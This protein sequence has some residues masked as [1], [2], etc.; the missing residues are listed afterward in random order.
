MNARPPADPRSTRIRDLVF[1]LMDGGA[2]ARPP[3]PKVEWDLDA[4]PPSRRGRLVA[5]DAETRGG[6]SPSGQRPAV[7]VEGDPLDQAIAGLEALTREIQT[8]RQ[9]FA[10]ANQRLAGLMEVIIALVSFD[11]QKKAYVSDRNDVFDGMAAGLNMLGE[12]LSVTTV[13]KAH[14]D[15]I[16]ESMSDLLVVTDRDA[17]IRTVNQAACDL[18]GCPR[19]ELVDQHVEALFPELS[20]SDL[21]ET[22]GV[23]DQERSCRLKNGSDA[24]VSFS[25]SVLRGARGEAQGLVCVARDLTEKKSLEEER[26]RLGEA[27]QRQAIILEELSTPLIPINDEILVMPLIGTVDERRANQMVDTLLQGV[28]TRRTQ[29]AIIDITGIRTVEDQAVD[30]ILK[31]VQAVRLVGAEVVLTGVRPEV[32][33]LLVAQGYDL[34]RI[35]T[36]GSLQNGIVSA[37]KRKREATRT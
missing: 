9:T 13:S 8:M 17:R 11:Y 5:S 3:G 22:G 7:T 15:N 36:F 30:G 16:I 37:M 12:E 4:P 32:A 25:A 33:R 27:V 31:A 2:D 6:R 21:I 28:V 10:D 24:R 19:D 23:R 1:G 20:A 14:V 29:V 34:S 35:K 26:W 18:V